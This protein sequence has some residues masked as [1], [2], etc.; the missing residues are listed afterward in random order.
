MEPAHALTATAGAD[1]WPDPVEVLNEHG[2][3]PVVLLCEHASNALP[4]EYGRLGL[5]EEELSRHIAWD[6]GAAEVTRGLSAALDA[7]AFLGTLSRLL[8][9]LNRPF[10]A[11]SAMPALS[12]ATSIPGNVGLGAAERERRRRRV[13]DPYH[14]R[15][16]AHLDRRAA[17]GR[18]TV[19]VTVHSFTPVFLGVARPWHA[20]VLFERSAAL[21]EALI[22]RLSADGMLNVAANEP[23]KVERESDYAIPVHGT[24]RGLSAALLEIRNDLIDTPDGVAAWV[25][26][27]AAVLPDAVAE[28]VPGGSGA[29]STTK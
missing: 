1:D 10:E 21:A 14:A 2:G 8:V 15:V 17:G 7:P 19:L 23:Y 5:P 27:L 25:E 18:T 4:A 22:R 16:A 3:S 28:T 29:G 9:D 24:D 6:I 12:E 20:G 13:F 26:R 11:P